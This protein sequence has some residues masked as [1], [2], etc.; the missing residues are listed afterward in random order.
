[1][2]TLDRKA[3]KFHVKQDWVSVAVSRV[4]VFHVKRA[5]SGGCSFHVK[6]APD[7]SCIGRIHRM[8]RIDPIIRTNSDV[9]RNKLAFSDFVLHD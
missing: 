3:T 5:I 2:A 8:S 6:R 9:V 4:C 1:M 7:N